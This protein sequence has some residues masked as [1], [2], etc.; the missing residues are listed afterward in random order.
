MHS[1]VIR[2]TASMCLIFIFKHLTV[3]C[4]S[5]SYKY[6]TV[7]IM[8]STSISKMAMSLLS[9]MYFLSFFYHWQEL[10]NLT[11]S[12]TTSVI[13]ET[14]YHSWALGFSP[15]STFLSIFFYCFWFSFCFSSLCLLFPILPV[16]R[17]YPSV[18]SFR[19]S[20]TFIFEPYSYQ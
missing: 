3:S 7:V 15:G 20:R 5:D 16:S 6:H 17:D 10:P 14:V 11:M 2:Y 9:F 18:I 19:F 8:N 13:E 1:T 4:W 12:N